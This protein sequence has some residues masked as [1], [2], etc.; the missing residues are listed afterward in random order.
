MKN[1]F[2]GIQGNTSI[3][4]KYYVFLVFACMLSLL[5]VIQPFR[6]F[7]EKRYVSGHTDKMNNNS[8]LV[9]PFTLDRASSSIGFTIATF[10]EEINTGN[11]TV[12]ISDA[13]TGEQKLVQVFD[14]PELADNRKL[15]IEKVLEP[16]NYKISFTFDDLEEDKNIV[17]YTYNRSEKSCFINNR[18]K[19]YE[20]ALDIS[21]V[22]NLEAVNRVYILITA[23]I[24][25]IA[26]LS[27]AF[28]IRRQIRAN[29][30]EKRTILTQN[31]IA[32]ICLFAAVTLLY[33][34]FHEM[35][36]SGTTDYLRD[37]RER[38]YLIVVL[39]AINLYLLSEKS[40]WIC[41]LL[42]GM[43]GTVWIFTDLR[44]SIID[45]GAH[46]E[47]VEYILGNR[48][49][50]PLVSQNYEAVQSP[51]YYYVTAL[52]VGWLPKDYLYLGARVEGMLFIL[53][54]GWITRMTI[55]E[56]K[57]VN[58][59]RGSERLPN[60]LWLLFVINP[61]M[62]IRFTRVSNEA[63]M[64]VFSALTILLVTRM[65]VRGFDSR[66]LFFAT[67]F[68]AMAFLTKSTSVVLVVLIFMACAYHHQW[69]NL[70]LQAGFYLVLVAP[71]FIW[72]YKR[73]GALTGMQQHLDYVLP[74]VNP[75]MVMPDIRGD[76]MNYF[77]M[78]FINVESGR[79]YDAG[80]YNSC[81]YPL[82]M[83]MLI[84]ATVV[85][86]QY[87]VKCLRKRLRFTYELEEKKDT[88]LLSFILLPVATLA[89]HAL[90]TAM[91]RNN[92]LAQNRYCFM[93]NGAFCSMLLIALKP[94]SERNKRI[95][96]GIV[97]AYFAYIM[98][99]MICGYTETVTAAL[100]IT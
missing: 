61:N 25:L 29:P 90:Q 28:S 45:E 32:L 3:K 84:V 68:S 53:L 95:V 11:L 98:L 1:P 27:V 69:K 80:Y 44:Y 48:W 96:A 39:L 71:W 63:L 56:I 26:G 66:T 74:I 93:I 33:I 50:F 67:F 22:P 52:L 19:D 79:W 31:V 16:G 81:L 23:C 54:F 2:R 76:F 8:W 94:V 58:W 30:G 7:A 13:D 87:M 10:L 85:S 12:K 97:A 86:I 49:R 5:S 18:K 43:I 83:L 100:M 40:P 60:L 37:N 9:Q 42:M 6:T 14:T 59:Y 70:F 99:S 35:L 91:T 89:M 20:I 41:W 21:Y 65:I 36:E 17:I 73:Y 46:T 88:L 55:D 72:N 64:C 78:Y 51:V 38:F 92:S 57:R 24:V 77:S 82:L 62:L 34:S 4:K 47:I 75:E 15:T